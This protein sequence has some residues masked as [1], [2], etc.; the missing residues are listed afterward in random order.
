MHFCLPREEFCPA[1]LHQAY[2]A[3]WTYA[4]VL[5]PIQNAN[6]CC[7]TL[8]TLVL[9]LERYL[10]ISKPVEYHNT[11]RSSGYWGRIL[12]YV[13]PVILFSFTFHIPKFFE[14]NITPNYSKVE[15]STEIRTEYSVRKF[16]VIPS[17]SIF[18]DIV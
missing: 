11:I 14:F 13:V 8:M 9:A 10:A 18:M 1:F 17:T 5:Y 16:V 6:L 7:S 3:M 4:R 15:N 12:R 2:F